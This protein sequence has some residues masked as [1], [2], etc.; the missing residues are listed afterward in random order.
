M[1]W[2]EAIVLGII[3][4]LTEFL[5]V[6][7]SGH[8][9][10]GSALFGMSGEEN[11]TFAIV[12]HTATVLSTIVVLWKEVSILFKG[13]FSFKWNEPTQMVCKILVSMI[14]VAIVGLF[15]KDYV[16]KLFGSGLL[17]VG[18]MLLVTAALLAFS[19]Y[20]KPRQKDEISFRDAFIIGIA[21]ACAVLPGLSRS[22][23]TIATGL[24]L[25][26][27]KEQVAKFSFLM[28]IIPILGE[29]FLSLV[30]GEFSP[31]ASGISTGALVA[32][33]LAAFISGTLACKWMI[34]IVKRGKLI[35]FAYYCLAAGL[36]TIIYS[37]I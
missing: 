33:F 20:A 35:Y 11:L 18:C 15:F 26:D 28:V 32:G 5:P 19:Y 24:L 17:L 22:G 34:N 31:E 29:S 12:V 16:E 13:F 36:F 14:P 30:K 4:G 25:G 37:L 7:S 1:G 9:T 27:K 10:I 21:Q 3:Q 2:L 23:S 6:S 8:L